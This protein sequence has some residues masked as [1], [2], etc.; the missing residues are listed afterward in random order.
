MLSARRIEEGAGSLIGLGVKCY[1]YG[2]PSPTFRG[3]LFIRPS[4][5]SFLELTQRT[6]GDI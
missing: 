6:T 1:S 2:R 5:L 4:L 3:S